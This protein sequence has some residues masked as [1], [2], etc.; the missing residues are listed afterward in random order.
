MS[1]FAS[2]F[3]IHL[4]MIDNVVTVHAAR[5]GLKV[6]RT[7]RVRNPQCLQIRSNVGCIIECEIRMQLQPVGRGRNAQH[8]SRG[9]GFQLML[10]D[11]GTKTQP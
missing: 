10:V 9:T 1:F 4:L 6:W 8:I 5:S 3:V 11:G 7:I 2:E